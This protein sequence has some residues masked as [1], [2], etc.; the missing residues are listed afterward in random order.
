MKTTPAQK[1][2]VT[3]LP[4]RL[5][6][7]RGALGAVYEF[8]AA[9]VVDAAIDRIHQTAAFEDLLAAVEALRATHTTWA[10]ER[11]IAAALDLAD[12]AIEKAR[13]A[14]SEPKEVWP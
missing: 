3:N 1:A 2:D 5:R 7:A 4:D 13:T 11:E 14:L 12:N 9:K 6:Y 10:S 8:G